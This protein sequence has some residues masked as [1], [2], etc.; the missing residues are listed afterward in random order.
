M[1]D[2]PFPPSATPLTPA[3]EQRRESPVTD[4]TAIRGVC[5]Y[6]GSASRVKESYKRH[7]AELGKRLA[8][9]KFDLVYGGGRVGL[10]GIAAD[11]AL[12][13]GGRVIGII[14]EHIQSVEM[15]HDGLTELHVVNSMH[16]RKRMMAERADAYVVL[17]GGFGTLDETFEII[18]W[19]RLRLHN[20]PIIFL[21]DGGYWKPLTGLL[22]HLIEAGFG[23]PEDRMLYQVAA[24][25][26][27]VMRLLEA[28]GGN[29]A[30][31][32]SGLM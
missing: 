12:A 17:P 11:A 29:G 28:P 14:P 16:T 20:K 13:A 30:G 24:T 32:K 26:D 10:M 1:K 9:G 2:N 7:A 8:E 31:V 18:T 3:G 4:I 22:E 27:D 21:D 25:L 19:K 15:K 23:I 5:V 6:C